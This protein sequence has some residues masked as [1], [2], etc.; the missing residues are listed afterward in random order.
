[1]AAIGYKKEAKSTYLP[2]SRTHCR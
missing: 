2:M 1:L